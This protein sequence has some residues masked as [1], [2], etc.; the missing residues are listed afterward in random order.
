MGRSPTDPHPETKAVIGG[1]SMVEMSS[2]EEALEWA[3]KIAVVC[4]CA[5]EARQ[6]MPDP[7]VCSAHHPVDVF[8]E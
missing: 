6:I 1:F 2:R 4:P 8:D 5:Q 3:A 7:D